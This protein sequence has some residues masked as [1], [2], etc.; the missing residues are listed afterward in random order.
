MGIVSL[1]TFPESLYSNNTESF[2]LYF[3]SGV[4][5]YGNSAKLPQ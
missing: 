5:N 3:P 2:K 4:L 1:Q